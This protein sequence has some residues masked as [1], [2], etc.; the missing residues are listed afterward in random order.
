MESLSVCENNEMQNAYL[1][2]REWYEGFLWAQTVAWS[3][4]L[5][6]ISVAFELIKNAT[7]IMTLDISR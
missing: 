7:I 3:F 6:M 4:L 2:T 5:C 1:L